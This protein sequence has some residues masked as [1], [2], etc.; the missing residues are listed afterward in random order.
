M[1]SI[2]NLESSKQAATYFARDDYYHGSTQHQPSV[3]WGRGAQMLRLEGAVERESFENVLEGNLPNGRSLPRNAGGERRPG[4]DLTFSA[5]KSVSLLALVH[6]SKDVV[7][8]H[9]AAVSEA[10]GFLE[11]EASVARTTSGGISRA[12]DTN[13]L[14]I[15]RFSHDTSRDLDP[16]L[17]SH[18]VVINATRRKDGEWRSISNERI[19]ALKMVG[20]AIYRARLVTELQ[21]LGYD[22]ERTHADGRFEV[23]GFTRDQLEHFSTRRAAIEEALAERGLDGAIAAKQAALITREV[24]REVDRGRLLEAW[25]S[26]AREIAVS[27]P[28]PSPRKVSRVLSREA[29]DRAVR[30]AIDHL[31]ERRT[32]FEERRLLAYALGQA[33]GKATLR[34]VAAALEKRIASHELIEERGPTRSALRAF[35]TA[36]AVAMEQALVASVRLEQGRQAP[37]VS[38]KR[39]RSLL[40]PLVLTDGQRSAAELILSTQ[41]GIVGIQGYAGTGKTTAL[42]TV[43]E[44]AESAGYDVRGFAPSAAAAA[45]LQEEAGIPSQTVASHLI[46]QA[47]G[48]PDRAAQKLW[49]VD[50]ASMLGTKDALRMIQTATRANAHLVLVGDWDQ[51]PSVDGGA[52]FRLLAARGMA[53]ASMDEIVRQRNPILKLAVEKTIARTGEEL[54]LLAPAIHEI[55]DRRARLDAVAKAFLE[56]APDADLLVLTSSNAD[57]RALNERIRAGLVAEGRLSGREQTTEVLAGRGLTTAEAEEATHYRVG[58]VV[59]FERTYK[60][61]GIEKGEYLLVHSIDPDSNRIMLE[62]NRIAWDPSHASRV[63]VYKRESRA[64]AVGDR[65]RWTRND[66]TAQR[67][68]GEIARVVQ[69]QEDHAILIQSG[70]TQRLEFG[71]D[72][73]WD[74]AYASTVHAAQG[75]T[76]D[77]VILHLDT[78]RSEITGHESWYVGLSRA[79]D[80]VR[81]F[82]DDARRLP[83]LIKKSLVQEIALDVVGPKLEIDRGASRSPGHAWELGR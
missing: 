45:V 27:F 68:N 63:E 33:T 5:P 29:A 12:E 46:D 66:R 35:T 41:D 74:H 20:G 72:R 34:E 57:R 56:R 70:K 48:W 53:I 69:V 62:G 26:R 19:Y 11:K 80:G 49:I 15:A 78:E 31:S 38:L 2:R 16:Q 59:R 71:A 17:H 64:L 18:C 14:L 67:R 30:L 75:R 42:R 13:N 61:F 25:R 52:P 81:I 83:D 8:A 32:V 39:T 55:R 51:L 28:E 65:I 24:K 44:L 22:I 40:E 43:R 60:R 10:P 4:L 54:E 79:R 9:E 82:T 73:H 77:S 76:A 23:R 6:R 36:E 47:R 37:I 3:W 7:L 1:L 21:R 58:D 50:E